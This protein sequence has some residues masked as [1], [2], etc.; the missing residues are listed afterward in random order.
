MKQPVELADLARPRK[1][2]L[3]HIDVIRAVVETGTVTNAAAVLDISQPAVS[4]TLRECSEILGFPLFLRQHGGLR[5]TPETLLLMPELQKMHEGME[6]LGRMASDIREAQTGFV[7]VAIVPLVAD[8]LLP[9]VMRRTLEQHEKLQISVQGISNDEVIKKVET[10]QVEFGLA[11]S[12]HPSQSEH[13]ID[14]LTTPLTFICSPTHPLASNSIICPDDLSETP[15]ITFNRSLP[16]GIILENT[17]RQS[18]VRRLTAVEITHTSTAKEL[19]RQNLGVSIVPHVALHTAED[20]LLR[21]I[22]FQ[23]E[24][25]IIVQMWVPPRRH[26]SGMARRVMQ[27]FRKVADEVQIR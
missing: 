27:L 10:G 19:V 1:L 9:L 4:M 11:L 7:S 25:N 6:R 22:P 8:T 3:R 16:I 24:T 5:P 15:L 23:P 20:A 18:A 2:T 14:L 12:H 13:V 17:F 21:A 26:P